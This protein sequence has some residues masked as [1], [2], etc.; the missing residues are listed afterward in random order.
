MLSGMKKYFIVLA[1]FGILV[2]ASAQITQVPKKCIIAHRG[3]WNGTGAAQNSINSLRNAAKAGVYGSEFD[4]WQ[5]TD[6]V[7]VVC[8]DR[9]HAGMPVDSSTYGELRGKPLSD[10]EPIP[11]LA[12]YM[13]EGKKSPADFRL[14]LEIKKA[15]VDRV[16]NTLDS[17]KI[18]GKVEFISFSYKYCKQLIDKKRGFKVSYLGGNVSPDSLYKD[19]FYGLDYYSS[20]FDAHPEWFGR[21]KELGLKINIWT[22]D[23]IENIAKY[24]DMGAD[25]LTTNTPFFVSDPVISVGDGQLKLSCKDGSANIFYTF[26][27]SNPASKGIEYKSPVKIAKRT[28]VKAVAKRDGY[29]DSNIVTYRK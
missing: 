26:D 1:L 29:F 13:E 12:E 2:S 17:M 20:V 8:H 9:F 15:N 27:K 5:T 4:V 21:A 16:V 28:V 11:T 22:I 18:T 19:G 10:G 7:L 24:Y 3:F 6:D 23:K 25:F 14:I